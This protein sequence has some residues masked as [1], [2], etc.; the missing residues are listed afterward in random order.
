MFTYSRRGYSVYHKE[1]PY[2]LVIGSER[3]KGSGKGKYQGVRQIAFLHYYA[4]EK[5]EKY[6]LELKQ[7]GIATSADAPIFLALHNN[8]FNKG[9]GDRLQSLTIMFYVASIMA[10]K[11][12]LKTKG[13]QH[14]ILGTFYRRHLKRLK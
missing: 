7:K 1:V 14:K 6:K 9:K 5:I 10:W 13:S 12:M 8:A 3:M 2:Y 4:A 11:I